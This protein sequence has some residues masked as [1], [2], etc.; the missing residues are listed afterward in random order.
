MVRLVPDGCFP[1]GNRGPHGVES[2]REPLELG[3][4]RRRHI[5]SIV[6]RFEALRRLR[7][8][9]DRLRGT[10]RQPHR[11]GGSDRKQQCSDR[12]HRVPDIVV[13]PQRTREGSLQDQA[14]VTVCRPNRVRPR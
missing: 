4:A 12:K 5:D 7:Q 11:K 1:I 9:L 13:G 8:I 10:A 3:G 2:A 6:A 14:Q